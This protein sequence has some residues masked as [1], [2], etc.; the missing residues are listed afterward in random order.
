MGI[1]AAKVACPSHKC[2]PSA[3][4]PSEGSRKDLQP[5]PTQGPL[6]SHNL[7]TTWRMEDVLGGQCREL[8]GLQ[9]HV[10]GSMVWSSHG[11]REESKKAKDSCSS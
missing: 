9:G 11:S 5:V 2:A 8:Q 3:G 7:S 4:H 1:K 6:E 10:E